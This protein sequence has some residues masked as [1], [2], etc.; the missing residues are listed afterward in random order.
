[1]ARPKGIKHTEEWKR[2][3]SQMSKGHIVSV[4]TRKKIGLANKN[5]IRS[6]E[7]K[8]VLS[9][10]NKGKHLSQETKDKISNSMKGEK[11]YR[12]KGGKSNK[13]EKLRHTKEVRLWKVSVFIR[14]NN[15]CINCNST[16]N[17]IAHHIFSFSLYP[18][19]RTSIENG[20]TLCKICHDLFHK[21]YGN[22]DNNKEQLEEFLSM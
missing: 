4:E 6:E 15:S 21:I 13:Q 19:L 5:K 3:I 20:A 22:M 17:K 11:S 2:N 12:W 10:I 9:V 7:F 18:E 8:K 16:I 14:D 1:M